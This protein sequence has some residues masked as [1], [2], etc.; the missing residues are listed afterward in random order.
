MALSNSTRPA[1][2]YEGWEV[3]PIGLGRPKVQASMKSSPLHSRNDWFRS[4]RQST[5]SQRI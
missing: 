2:L 5:R 4:A 1:Q 3:S